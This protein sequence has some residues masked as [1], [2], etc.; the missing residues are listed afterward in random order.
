MMQQWRRLVVSIQQG[1]TF[2]R[3]VASKQTKTSAVAVSL[4]AKIS[5]KI[6]KK[7]S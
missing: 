4:A 3:T 1:D 7:K 5:V 6:T 2:V